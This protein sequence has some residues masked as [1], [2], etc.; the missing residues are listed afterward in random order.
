MSSNSNNYPRQNL[1]SNNIYPNNQPQTPNNPNNNSIN[2]NG[3]S[4]ITG[5]TDTLHFVNPEIN[6]RTKYNSYEIAYCCYIF[7]IGLFI[8]ISSVIIDISA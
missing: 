5:A 6:D 1:N 4:P 3:S 7:W 8:I 2:P